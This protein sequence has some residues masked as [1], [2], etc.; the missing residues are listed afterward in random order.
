ME[1]IRR[2]VELGPKNDTQVA[3]V[4]GLNEGDEIALTQVRSQ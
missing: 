4:A 3:I 2:A 1:F